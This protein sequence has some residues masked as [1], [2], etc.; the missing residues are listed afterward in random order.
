MR[1]QRRVLNR[2]GAWPN[3]CLRMTMCSWSSPKMA[4]IIGT[5]PPSVNKHDKLPSIGL[6]HALLP[7]NLRWPSNLLFPKEW[8][9][10]KVW[11][12]YTQAL[13]GFPAPTSSFMDAEYY[14]RSLTTLRPSQYEK[15]QSSHVKRPNGRERKN[16]PNSLT[17]YLEHSQ[18]VLG[19]LESA[20][21]T[22]IVEWKQVIVAMSCPNF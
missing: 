8:N 10:C 15:T 1:R 16:P 12:F 6:V 5:F 13:R 20:E 17:Q 22:D 19:Q 7:W 11:E 4:A 14:I 3:Y 2:G 9:T 21:T 18:T